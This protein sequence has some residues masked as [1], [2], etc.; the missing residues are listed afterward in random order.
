M[1]ANEKSHEKL[2]KIYRMM[3]LENEKEPHEGAP[4]TG[5]ID[6]RTRHTKG[7]HLT[8]NTHE[9]TEIHKIDSQYH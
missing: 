3:P 2:L 7:I 5:E 1:D 6:Y 4:Y 9:L 8:L